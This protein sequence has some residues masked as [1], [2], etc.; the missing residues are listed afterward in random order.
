M[1]FDL[2]EFVIVFLVIAVLFVAFFVATDQPLFPRPER[3]SPFIIELPPMQ[4][5]DPTSDGPQASQ[6]APA[7][8]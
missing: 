6:Q 5:V 3:S 7:S 8:P 1:R 4:P 2:E